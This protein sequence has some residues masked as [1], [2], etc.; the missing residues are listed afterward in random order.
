MISG[1]CI[2]YPYKNFWSKE[3]VAP[4]IIAGLTR[5]VLPIIIAAAAIEILGIHASVFYLLVGWSI[6]CEISYYLLYPFLRLIIES[7]KGWLN[8]LIL[9]YFPT[10]L[11]FWFFPL[12]LVNYPGVGFYYVIC[13][14]F[15]C[16]LLGLLLCYTTNPNKNKLFISKK[17]LLFHRIFILALA[18]ST[19]IL[20]LQEL[21]G[22][23]FTLNF[24]AIAAFFWL[25]KEIAYYNEKPTIKLLDSLGKA[26]YS[27]YLMHG[28]PF[29]F[30]NSI[31]VELGPSSKFF[32]YWIILIILT[33]AFYF[34]IEKPTHN[35]SRKLFK[36][37]LLKKASYSNCSF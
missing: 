11:V 14:G 20:A 5:I 2:H 19:H 34:F 10:I 9:S 8:L 33:T 32:L 30:I 36:Y 6:V 17:N 26:S 22:H 24:F 35:L 25:K 31:T 28:I 23:P 16:W 12:K 18:L 21:I 3:T 13:L 1:F 27:I 37:F 4:F 29:F 15:P 7:K